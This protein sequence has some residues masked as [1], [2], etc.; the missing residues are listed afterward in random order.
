[1]LHVCVTTLLKVCVTK[2]GFPTDV[3]VKIR[4]RVFWD[5]IE[6]SLTVIYTVHGLVLCLEDAGNSFL[7]K[8]G[9]NNLLSDPMT[10]YLRRQ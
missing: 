8:A 10:S 2:F 7:R 1:M 4:L 5:L 6:C 3:A 9:T